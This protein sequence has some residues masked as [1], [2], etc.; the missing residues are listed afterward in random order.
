MI[1]TTQTTANQIQNYLQHNITLDELVNWAENVIMEGDF[2]QN[3]YQSLRDIVA[4]I[5]LGDSQGFGITWEELQ[6]Y[7]DKLGYKT[8]IEIISKDMDNRDFGDFIISDKK[9]KD[10]SKEDEDNNSGNTKK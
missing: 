7:L 8:R 5:G 9:R 2:E 4:K 1:I 3:N 10:I 6:S